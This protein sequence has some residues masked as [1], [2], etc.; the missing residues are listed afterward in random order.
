MSIARYFF[1]VNFQKYKPL[2]NSVHTKFHE[3]RWAR[4]RSHNS[5]PFNSSV[6]A[7][8]IQVNSFIYRL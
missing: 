2:K 7:R 4:L 3:N 1:L 6:V 8:L 5:S